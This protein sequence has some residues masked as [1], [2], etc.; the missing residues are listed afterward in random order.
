[1]ERKWI[2][3]IDGEMEMVVTERSSGQ[4][5][6]TSCID[7]LIK[8]PRLLVYLFVCFVIK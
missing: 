6:E 7:L 1:M 5:G 3:K 8:K 4:L 2:L